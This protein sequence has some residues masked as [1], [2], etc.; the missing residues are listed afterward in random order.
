MDTLHK[1]IL[2]F[3]AE[4]KGKLL[5]A[6]AGTGELSRALSDMGF[7]VSSCDIEPDVFRHGRCRKVDLNQ[8]LPYRK[9]EFDHVVCSEVV[10]HIENP[11]HLF[12]QVN[13]VM[14]KGGTLVITTPNI[15]N[16][17]SRVKFLL[18]GKFFC[19]SD[20]ERRLGHLNPV[21]WW[22]LDEALQKH[23]FVVEKVSSNAYLMLS[24]CDNPSSAMKRSA[25]RAIY[26]ILY[27]FIKPKNI[28]LLKG[29]SL[30]FLARKVR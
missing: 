24:G 2:G 29:D 14:K 25:A 20:E 13:R 19:F 21:A 17:F 22:E 5:D 4:K 6:G 1:Q 16:V 10:E 18:T 8:D 12:R 26:L 23:G 11:H 7:S 15:A 3:M 28:E 27:P 30:V 9:N